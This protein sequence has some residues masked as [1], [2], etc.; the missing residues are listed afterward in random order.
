[1]ALHDVLG[2][3]RRK[4]GLTQ[5]QAAKLMRTPVRT[6]QAWERGEFAVPTASLELLCLKLGEDVREHLGIDPMSV[7]PREVRHAQ[8][9]R[10]LRGKVSQLAGR[11][12]EA[13]R[14]LVAA[15][16]EA[17]DVEKS[18]DSYLED[19]PEDPDGD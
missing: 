19:A 17:A 13:E 18:I 10:A 8:N 5:V 7:K 6:Y 9:L 3:L 2:R 11:I 14:T 15:R 1:V 12:A 4:H 16:R